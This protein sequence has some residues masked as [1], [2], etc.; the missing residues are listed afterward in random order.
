VRSDGVQRGA[1]S[2][3]WLAL[4]MTRPGLA[5]VGVCRRS[6]PGLK[7]HAHRGED[8]GLRAR[9]LWC[10]ERLIRIGH[11]DRLENLGHQPLPPA[12]LPGGRSSDR[13]RSHPG[14]CRAKGSAAARSISEK[15]ARGARDRIGLSAWCG[16]V[17]ERAAGRSL[18]RFRG[19]SAGL[20]RC[21]HQFCGRG[22]AQLRARQRQPRRGYEGLTGSRAACRTRQ[23]G[24]APLIAWA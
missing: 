1:S 19:S 20:A 17:S 21:G 12:V 11:R 5:I 7:P 15:T 6:P 2:R 22:P 9:G 16:S 3:H 14:S 23:F 10:L 24:E 13:R 8:A 4:R 18:Y